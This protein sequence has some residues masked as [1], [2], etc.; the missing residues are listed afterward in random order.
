LPNDIEDVAARPQGAAADDGTRKMYVTQARLAVTLGL[1]TRTVRQRV[2]DGAFD[3]PAPD[4]T[5]DIGQAARGELARL[6]EALAHARSGMDEKTRAARARLYVARAEIAEKEA[7][8]LSGDLMSALPVL[9]RIIL[10]ARDR[11]LAIPTKCAARV[12]ADTRNV[13]L[14]TTTDEI[15]DALNELS[16]VEALTGKTR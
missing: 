1:S 12:P 7:K 14:T 8:R 5:H 13:V 16:K 11:L 4:G 10:I 2:A 9:Q 3:P 6:R 15:Y